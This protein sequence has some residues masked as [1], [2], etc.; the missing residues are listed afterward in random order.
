MTKDMTP[1]RLGVSV[2]GLRNIFSNS[3]SSE[4]E[5]ETKNSIETNATAAS[6]RSIP[7]SL[8]GPVKSSGSLTATISNGEG[9]EM[10]ENDDVETKSF[11]MLNMLRNAFPSPERSIRSSPKSTGEDSE[12]MMNRMKK[13]LNMSP[14]SLPSYSISERSYSPSA[15]MFSDSKDIS[16]GEFSLDSRGYASSPEQKVDLQNGSIYSDQI[17]RLNKHVRNTS[18]ISTS[19]DIIDT[20]GTTSDVSDSDGLEE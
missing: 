7:Q 16:V 14:V 13:V 1:I 2:R 9:D 17:D 18:L 15:G 4:E 12:G 6:G 3:K 11:G 10:E 19:R 8:E 20:D 5:D